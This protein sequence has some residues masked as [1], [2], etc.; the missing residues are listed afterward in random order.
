MT[1]RS[2]NDE[3]VRRRRR[4]FAAQLAPLALVLVVAGGLL[5]RGSGVLGAVG[6]TAL[7]QGIGL[8]VA[9][10]WLAAGRNPLSKG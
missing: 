6:A 1:A 2:S 3:A 7:A 10:I 9:V 4:R 8:F 5:A